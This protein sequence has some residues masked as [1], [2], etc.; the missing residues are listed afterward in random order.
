MALTS[1]LALVLL[2][3]LPAKAHFIAD[4]EWVYRT[5]NS[6]CVQVRS[7]V[8]HGTD[9][10]YSRNDTFSRNKGAGPSFDPCADRLYV[11]A[12]RIAAK[13]DYLTWSPLFGEWLVCKVH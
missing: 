5:E 3:A 9:A 2:T 11:Y 12:D 13:Y 10:G 4:I 8:S 7:E 1:A 6:N